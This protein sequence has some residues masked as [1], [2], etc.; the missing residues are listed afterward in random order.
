MTN[1]QTAIKKISAYISVKQITAEIA[2]K[3]Y[4]I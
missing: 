1:K 4:I 3:N 2:K